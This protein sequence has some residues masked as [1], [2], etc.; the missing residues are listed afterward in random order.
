LTRH[1]ATRQA[2]AT[3][4]VIHQYDQAFGVLATRLQQNLVS[5]NDQTVAGQQGQ[6]L[7]ESFVNCGATTADIGVVKRGHVIVH[8]GSTVHEL[9]SHRGR[10]REL[11]FIVTAGSSH[12][13]AQLGA[14][15]GP[16]GKHGVL[17]GSLQAGRSSH[18]GG[19]LKV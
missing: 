5:H 6:G 9:Q 17:H 15:S 8:Q 14:D 16:A 19:G 1:D 7:A 18:T 12:C 2:Y 13:H 3:R 4:Q 10:I 11:R